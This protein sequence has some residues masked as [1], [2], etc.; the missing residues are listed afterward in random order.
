MDRIAKIKDLLEEKK[1]LDVM[2]YDLRDKD[3][4]VD[5]VIVATAMADKHA[6]ALLDYLKKTLK[7]M[8]E[9]FLGVDESNDW[10]AIDLGDIL[11]HLMSEEY[12]ARYQ[13]DKFLKD[14][15]LKMR[16]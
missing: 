14:L 16:Q 4:F 9:T 10:I 13:M 5:Y 15:K 11:I 2:E 6:Q 3:Y 12:R 8:G 1:A 7:P